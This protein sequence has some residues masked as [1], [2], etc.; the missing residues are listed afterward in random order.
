[1]EEEALPEFEKLVDITRQSAM[2][3]GAWFVKTR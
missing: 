2:Q 1:M 3:I